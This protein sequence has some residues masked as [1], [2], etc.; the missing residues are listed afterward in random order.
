MSDCLFCKIVE[1]KIPS[2]RIHEDEKVIGFKD[3]R[4]QADIHLLFIHRRHTKD[5]NDLAKNDPSQLADLF[6]AIQIYTEKEGLTKDG[7]R[8]VTN[9]GAN[10]GQTVFHTHLHVL[11]GEPLGHFGR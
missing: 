4:P 11:A 9:L 1:G 8:V 10:A 5:I 7:F 3:L 2:T 6:G